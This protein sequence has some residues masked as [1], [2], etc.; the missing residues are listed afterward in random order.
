MPVPGDDASP[1]KSYRPSLIASAPTSHRLRAP[2]LGTTEP[3]RSLADS[4]E[5][6]Q[7]QGQAAGAEAGPVRADGASGEPL[8]AEGGALAVAA[9]ADAKPTPFTAFVE[10]TTVSVDGQ[11]LTRLSQ[12]EALKLIL[13]GEP[14]ENAFIDALHLGYLADTWVKPSDVGTTQYL[15]NHFKVPTR[16]DVADVGAAGGK[17]DIARLKYERPITLKNCILGAFSAVGCEFACPLSL[18]HCH[19]QGDV[20]L[21]PPDAENLTASSSPLVPA[22]VCNEKL[23]IRDTR[24]DGKVLMQLARFD[25][26]VDLTGARLDGACAMAHTRVGGKLS[27]S[28]ALLRGSLTLS[29]ATLAGFDLTDAVFEGNSELNCA[30][31]TFN[32]LVDLSEAQ[33]FA[34]DLGGVMFNQPVRAFHFRV[35]DALR[36]SDSRFAEDCDFTKARVGDDFNCRRVVFAGR[37]TFDFLR[38]GNHSRFEES[39]FERE[40]SFVRA[41]SRDTADFRDCVFKGTVS[42]KAMLFYQWAIFFHAV[43]ETDV[44][45]FGARFEGECLFNKDRVSRDDEDWTLRERVATFGGKVSFRD[46]FFYR[47]I[48]LDGAAFPSTVAFDH[49]YFAE[50]ASIRDCQFAD[51]CDFYAAVVLQE[52]DVRQCVFEGRLLLR[53]LNCPGRVVMVGSRLGGVSFTNS[54]IDTLV[55]DRKQ[56]EGRLLAD[57]C[58]DEAERD[59]SACA[60]DFTLLKAAFFKRG[61][62]EDEDWAYANFK[63]RQRHAL[64]ATLKRDPSHP[65]AETI[66]R[67]PSV[68]SFGKRVFLRARLLVERCVF[69]WF[70]EY[71]TNPQRTGGLALLTIVAFGVFYFFAGLTGN[72]L[73]LE[74]SE[75]VGVDMNS[76]NPIDRFLF[77]IYFSFMAFTT[78]GF[79][80]VHPHYLGWVKYFVALEAF[81]GVFIITLFVGTFARKIIR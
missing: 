38:V 17:R 9:R 40:A 39:V 25:G 30:A 28:R 36:L 59:P 2:Q 5:L 68:V 1:R 47:K 79:G 35:T 23:T 15:A 67:G 43:F 80:D 50:Q 61:R 48:V 45:F 51:D 54:M 52:L 55:V 75:L 18:V 66:A 22:T 62:L 24:I 77:Y 6:P 7:P 57:G 69:D 33:V 73:V 20:R 65:K 41:Q 53:A 11:K 29:H 34:A 56:I 21:A 63:R 13:R 14:I 64:A 31:A 60:D 44:D 42:F 49:A 32:G 27:L 81:I 19:V 58:L 4:H 37:V 78:M 12:D 74:G 3:S 16:I 26:D 8:T 71:G 70:S 10:R 76:I 46:A 72:D